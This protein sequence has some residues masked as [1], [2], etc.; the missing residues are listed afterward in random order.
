M[1]DSIKA[2]GSS[3]KE[4]LKEVSK[5][6]IPSFLL[7]FTII[8]IIVFLCQSIYEAVH[9]SPF[10]S[11]FFLFLAFILYMKYRHSMSSIVNK[12]IGIMKRYLHM[13][14]DLIYELNFCED[15]F[16]ITFIEIK[17]CIKM[18]YSE[19]LE[20]IETENF[21][22]MKTKA[23][24]SIIIK[25]DSLNDLSD[26]DWKIFIKKKCTNAK[27]IKYKKRGKK[28]CLQ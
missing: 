4:A 20:I 14:D 9:H 11:I 17:K 26:D 10:M 6:L 21:Y 15:Y 5:Y 8:V 27:K 28:G 23:S 24:N 13:K 3:T 25:K 19:I 12:R 1:N 2:L 16:Y 22:L 7:P 18:P